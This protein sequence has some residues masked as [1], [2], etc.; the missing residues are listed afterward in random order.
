MMSDV[1]YGV[2]LSGGIDSS[3]LVA[4]ASK[5]SSQ[6]LNTFSIVFKEKILMKENIQKLFLT[7]QDKSS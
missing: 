2:F 3:I 7:V 1:P 5:V 4:A 6:K